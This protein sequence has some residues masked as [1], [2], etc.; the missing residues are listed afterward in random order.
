MSWKPVRSEPGPDLKLFQAR[1]DY[2]ENP[3]NGKI[4]RVVILES[5][6]SVNTL[7]FTREH[8]IIMVRQYR[9][10]VQAPTLELPGGLIDPGEHPLAAAKREL[11]EETGFGGGEWKALGEIQSNPVFM[12]SKMYHFQAVGVELE[13]H[14]QLDAEEDIE[15]V[16]LSS[17]EVQEM[18]REGVI[19]HPHVISALCRVFPIWHS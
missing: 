1:F 17:R 13:G 14:M 9:F 15:L 19:Q 5:A 7:A 8:K 4:A 11:R 2:L 3:R 6:D 18:V 12:D 16:F 10:G